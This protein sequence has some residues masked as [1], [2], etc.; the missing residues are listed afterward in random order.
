MKKL[1]THS[2][3]SYCTKAFKTKCRFGFPK[4]KCFGTRIFGNINFSE[5][6]KGNFYESKRSEK[7]SMINP[8]NLCILR[9]WRAN[10][11]IHVQLICNAEG[12]AY[13]VCSY[14]CKSES[15]EMKNAL[16]KL[17]KQLF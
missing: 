9:H 5:R 4:E 13:Y 1:Q 15:D 6:N 11:D 16:S 14:I 8:Y 2:H 7:D 10:M 12:A 3:T 17:I